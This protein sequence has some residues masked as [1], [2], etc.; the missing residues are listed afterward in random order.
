MQLKNHLTKCI[1]SQMPLPFDSVLPLW[2][3]HQQIM[4]HDKMTALS[5]TNIHVNKLSS[6]TSQCLPISFW[7]LLKVILPLLKIHELIYSLSAFMDTVM[8][9]FRQ[10]YSRIVTSMRCLMND[11]GS[12]K[13]IWGYHPINSS[14]SIWNLVF[15]QIMIFHLDCECIQKHHWCDPKYNII[16]LNTHK[17]L[18]SRCSH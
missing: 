3:T 18:V 5:F 12:N 16:A 17:T 15:D 8:I 6:V 4:Q 1:Y 14:Y 11:A 13:Y 2:I 10:W 9:N 7:M